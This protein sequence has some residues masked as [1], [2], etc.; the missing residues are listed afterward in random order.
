MA[1]MLMGSVAERIVQEAPCSVLLVRQSAT[2]DVKIW[3]GRRQGV[4]G[5]FVP[6]GNL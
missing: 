5:T 4:A 6:A 3:Y 1:H 2:R